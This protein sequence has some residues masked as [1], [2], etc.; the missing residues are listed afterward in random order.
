MEGKVQFQ[1]CRENCRRHSLSPSLAPSLTA[2]MAS[3]AREQMRRWRGVRPGTR[4]HSSLAPRPTA[5]VTALWGN[6]HLGVTGHRHT[7]GYSIR[8]QSR[9]TKG[10]VT[11]AAAAAATVSLVRTT[12]VYMEG[13][14]LAILYRIYSRYQVTVQLLT[15]KWRAAVESRGGRKITPS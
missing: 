4:E 7:S 13:K 2:T 12:A 3:G 1:R 5:G 14:I 8:S 10:V 15:S 6:S 11:I 9:I